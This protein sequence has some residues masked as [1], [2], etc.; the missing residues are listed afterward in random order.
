M[1]QGLFVDNELIIFRE[2]EKEGSVQW[3]FVSPLQGSFSLLPCDRLRR[4]RRFG[5]ES[6][7][8]PLV[9]ERSVPTR[10]EPEFG[11]RNEPERRRRLERAQ[12]FISA[13][14]YRKESFCKVWVTPSVSR[15]GGDFASWLLR[16]LMESGAERLEPRSCSSCKRMG[17]HSCSLSS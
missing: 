5:G 11:R 8:P 15:G 10:N 7:C 16:F 3:S 12:S 2:R 17:D 6:L 1:R 13:S 14:E 4:R 9:T